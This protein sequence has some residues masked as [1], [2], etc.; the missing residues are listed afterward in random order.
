[1]G[2]VRLEIS[3]SFASMLN[4]ADYKW[5]VLEKETE[6]WA[7]IGDLLSDIALDNTN[8]RKIVFDPHIGKVSDEVMVVLND[9]L[10]QLSDITEIKLKDGDTVFLLPMIAQG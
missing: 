7:T 1:M 2:K 9:N 10:L 4:V 8:F 6:K 5:I 3:P